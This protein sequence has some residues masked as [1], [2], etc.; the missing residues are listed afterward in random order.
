MRYVPANTPD[1]ALSFLLSLEAAGREHSNSSLLSHLT[2]TRRILEDWGARRAVALAGMF[3]SVYGTLS[4][5][6]LVDWGARPDVRRAIGDEAERLAY[7][8][9][10]MTPVTLLHNVDRH[11][12]PYIH[13]RFTGKWVF[14]DSTD[15]QDLCHIMAANWLEQFPRIPTVREP[16]REFLSMLHL[17]LPAARQAIEHAVSDQ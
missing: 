9:S 13:D 1:A 11:G 2:G 3:H 14:I 8:F 6:G 12:R 16:D 17:L 15:V 7:L 10:A 4:F 5:G